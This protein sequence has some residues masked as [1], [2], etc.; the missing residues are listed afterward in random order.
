MSKTVRLEP[1]VKLRD[2]DKMAKIPVKII[3]TENDEILRKPSWMKI[4]L[5]KSSARIQEIKDVMR[6]NNLHSVCE[7]ASCPNLSECF[8]HGTATFMIMGAICTRRCP[9][10]DVAHGK[11][12]PLVAEEP[13]KLAQTIAKMKLKYVVITSVD[14]DDLRRLISS[15]K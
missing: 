6:E 1:G 2:A 11:P 3:A 15:K 13:L 10:C 5:P 4:R 12:L 8:N 14:R 7:E 9:F